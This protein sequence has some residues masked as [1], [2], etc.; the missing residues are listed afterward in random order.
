[1]FDPEKPFV[2]WCEVCGKEELL[3]SEEA[4]R[5][6]WDFPPRMGV[7][8]VVSPRTCGQCPINATVWC[9]VAVDGYDAKQL[10]PEQREVA[11]RIHAESSE[12]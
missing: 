5:T 11:A 4:F 7:W 8:G 12:G 6:G 2:H 10:S 1:M 3:T 9:A